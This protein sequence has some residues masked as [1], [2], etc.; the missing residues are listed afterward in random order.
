MKLNNCLFCHEKPTEDQPTKENNEWFV[1]CW[2]CGAR[3]PICAAHDDYDDMLA[4]I[5]VVRGWN[6]EEYEYNDVYEQV[7]NEAIACK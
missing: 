4:K 1:E 6:N 7:I 2:N 3:G 5:C